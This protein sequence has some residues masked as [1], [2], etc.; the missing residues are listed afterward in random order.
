MKMVAARIGPAHGLRGEVIL[1][2]RSDDPQVISPGSILELD[3]GSCRTFTVEAT[4]QHKDRV[5]A[6]FA[7]IQSR[8]EAEE[9]RGAVLV[10][11]AHDEADA[12]YPHQLKGMSARTP[13]GSEL[14]T[15]VG[16]QPGAAQDLIL[17]R[18]DN[19]KVM[20]P[21][22]HQIVPEVNV[23]TATMTIDPPPGLFD[24]QAVIADGKSH[25]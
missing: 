15:V 17:V 21:F 11:D 22:V 14:G 1:D 8:E 9:L 12:W 13:S 25:E 5:L 7:E 24:D 6:F 20:V 16:L 2:V 3:D 4:R 18:T 23:E 10:V 19:G